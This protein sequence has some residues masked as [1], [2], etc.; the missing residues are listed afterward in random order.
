MF[1]RFCQH[2]LITFG[3]LA[4]TLS[5]TARATDFYWTGLGAV[6][7]DSVRE[8]QNPANWSTTV[9]GLTP[10]TVAPT[11]ADNVYLTNSTAYLGSKT[12]SIGTQ[13]VNNLTIVSGTNNIASRYTANQVDLIVNGSFEI[14]AGSFYTGAYSPNHVQFKGSFTAANGTTLGNT[15]STSDGGYWDLSAA[16]AINLNGTTLKQMTNNWMYGPQAWSFGTALITLTNTNTFNLEQNVVDSPGGSATASRGSLQIT[17][18]NQITGTGGITKTGNA[19]LILNNSASNYTGATTISHGVLVVGGG[20]AIG[21]TSAVTVA[22]YKGSTTGGDV[23]ATLVLTA[24]ETIGSLSGGGA[25]GGNVI[26]NGRTLTVGGNN[27]S[28]TFAGIIGGS[29][30]GATQG[31]RTGQGTTPIYSPYTA[32]GYIYSPLPALGAGNLVKTGSG[33]MT[34]SGASLYSGTTTL[35][36]GTLAVTAEVKKNTPGP[37][38]QSDTAIIWGNASTPNAADQNTGSVTFIVDKG[39]GAAVNWTMDRDLNGSA[40]TGTHVGRPRFLFNSSNTADTSTLTMSGNIT[41][42]S[43]SAPRYEFA[44]Q[45]SGMTLNLTGKISGGGA[46]V[47]WN[48]S[49]QGK[50][51]IRLGN[52]TNDYTAGNS[53]L[54]GTLILAGNVGATG[55][56]AIGTG[57][58]QFGDGAPPPI[59]ASGGSDVAPG[60]FMETPGATFA[61]DIT[62]AGV[63][64]Y[65]A[66][67]NGIPNGY[68]LGGVNTSGVVTFS[69]NLIFSGYS[70]ANAPTDAV[71]N[72][73]LFASSGGVVNFTG[74]IPDIATKS[75]TTRLVVNQFRNNPGLTV[76]PGAN[77]YVG[78]PT[79]G[80]VVLTGAK[81]YEGGTTVRGGSLLVNHTYTAAGSATGSGALEVDAASTFGGNGRITGK[82]TVN[83]G[84]FLAPGGNADTVAA[85]L[86]GLNTD[87]GTLKLDNGLALNAG[88]TV[89]MQLK[90][91]GTH[92][93]TPTYNPASGMLTSINGISVDGGNDRLIV[94]GDL[95]ADLDSAFTVTFGSGYTPGYQDTF[96]LLDWGTFNGGATIAISLYDDGDGL[97]AG[98]ITDNASFWLELPDLAAYNS[99]WMWDVSQFGTTGTISIVPEPGRALLLALALGLTALRR[100]RRMK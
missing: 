48:G 70:N 100:R 22:N 75:Q 52:S 9:D 29:A 92:G 77:A 44:A 10:A 98:G 99:A 38:G 84:A 88:A 96:D 62:L 61:R 69:G 25:N 20:N 57:A 50:G 68:R 18:N 42:T 87:V 35:R 74:A 40:L 37:L 21:D 23:R 58:I 86:S 65:S 11:S 36:Q 67:W 89:Q 64:T 83:S 85:G 47:L 76:D 46:S 5:G 60:L 59:N 16:T 4:A 90:T 24:D 19:S 33:Y 17:I 78:T 8:W 49:N 34:L 26:L 91:G 55:A 82:V 97:R 27:S 54:R 28:T 12:T 63:A 14:L 72:L 95:T 79:T 51:T 81:A 93:L 80:T 41:F 6:N 56:S 73:A 32:E 43:G 71:A 13:S 66:G 94:G 3:L 1:I 2:A 30:T 53:L 15:G 31:V 45:Q 7:A 39:A